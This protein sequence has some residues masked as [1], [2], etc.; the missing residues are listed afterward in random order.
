VVLNVATS[1]DNAN[2]AF[3]GLAIGFTVVTGAI[4]VGGV[5]G[6]AFN[7]AVGLGALVAVIASWSL[8]WIYLIGTLAGGAGAAYAFRALDPDDVDPAPTRNTATAK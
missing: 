4:T 6:G 3:Y 5:S 1:K 2:N 8:S 7:P